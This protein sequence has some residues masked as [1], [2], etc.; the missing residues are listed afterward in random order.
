MHQTVIIL[1]RNVDR[2]AITIG[3]KIMAIEG[4]VVV[5]I[6]ML[7]VAATTHN[8]RN[9]EHG[10]NSHNNGD[11]IHHGVGPQPWAA[12]RCQYPTSSWTRPPPARQPGILGNRQQQA[13]AASVPT[14]S[15]YDPTEIEQAMHTMTLNTPDTNWYMDTDA[16]SHMTASPGFSDGDANNDM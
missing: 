8:S 2:I 12:P 1:L 5:A 11:S 6:T 16:T 3:A 13:Y 15:S 10:N 9:S 7:M 4:V 14:S